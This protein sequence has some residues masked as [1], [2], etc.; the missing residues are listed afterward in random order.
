M[1]GRVA[2]LHPAL[3]VAADGRRLPG[4]DRRPRYGDITD[5]SDFGGA[6]IDRARL[7]QERHAIERAKSAA[8]DT[9]AVGGEY[10]DRVGYFVRPTVLLSDDPADEAFTT[11]YFGP[12]LS[13]HV[14]PDDEYERR[15]RRHRHRI[16]LRADRCG[17]RRRPR[18]R[19][20]A[21]DRLRFAAGNF[22]VND[23]PTG[24]VVGRQPFGGRA[25]RAPT[26]RPGRR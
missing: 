17:L 5:L 22:Y 4:R 7:R 26:T 1:L 11:E 8:G 3:G 20:T 13:V 9:I 6:V 2:G 10:D 14:Y 21:Q 16:P 15:P 19:A 23:K 25:V 24:A 12:M 18:G